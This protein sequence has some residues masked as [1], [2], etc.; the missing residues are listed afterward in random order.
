MILNGRLVI[1]GPRGEIIRPRDLPDTPRRKVSKRD[2]KHHAKGPRRE[3]A[4]A[5]P[6]AF[7]T[8]G[9]NPPARNAWGIP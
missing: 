3:R 7:L 6:W 1:I 4:K 5:Y 2:A 9:K 8:E